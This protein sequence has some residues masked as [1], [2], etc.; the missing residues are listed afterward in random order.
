MGTDKGRSGFWMSANTDRKNWL[1]GA[2][3][4]Q[5]ELK[6]VALLAG[7]EPLLRCYAEN[8]DVHRITA[9]EVLGLTNGTEVE[10]DLAKI[11]EYG[12]LYSASE[13]VQTVWRQSVAK[14]SEKYPDIGQALTINRMAGFRKRWFAAHPALARWQKKI[15]QDAE[16]D[17]FVEAPLSG[18]RRYFVDGNVDPNEALN[19]QCQAT[20]AD[21]T[22]RA[23]LKI[24]KELDWSYEYLVAQLHDALYWEGPD[25]FRLARIIKNGMEQEVHL[26]GNSLLFNV[27]LGIGKDLK[28]LHK[29]T[30]LPECDFQEFLSSLS[31]SPSP[32]APQQ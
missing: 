11:V 8:K 12:F 18:R 25:P 29:V 7:D 20:A 16:R 17:K 32:V 5:L 24:D 10:R 31:F 19:F 3:F 26:N 1:V 4:S 23:V 14:L 2:D 13:D 9:T 21:L 27:D 6:I 22:N 28:N 15:I 30:K